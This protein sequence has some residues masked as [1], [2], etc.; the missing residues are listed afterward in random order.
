MQRE[1]QA[2][3]EEEK[4]ILQEDL[5][6]KDAAIMAARREYWTQIREEMLA[7][8]K[9]LPTGRKQK[10]KKE[11][12]QNIPKREGWLFSKEFFSLLFI[13]NNQMNFNDDL[14]TLLAE[15]NDSS[16]IKKFDDSKKYNAQ[17]QLKNSWF[18][19]IWEFQV[20]WKTKEGAKIVHS[21][22]GSE[23]P[24][25]SEIMGDWFSRTI[26]YGIRP[27]DW[28]ERAKNYMVALDYYMANRIFNVIGIWNSEE[29]ENLDVWFLLVACRFIMENNLVLAKSRVVRGLEI[30]PDHPLLQKLGKLVESGVKA[31]NFDPWVFLQG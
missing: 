12:V 10:V 28:L 19:G 15:W 20:F 23:I 29:L 5:R 14:A 6:T 4:K 18:D 9:D 22:K 11:I 3:A 21:V 1:A 26:T 13:I 31:E 2:R 27:D 16:K 25:A 17:L 7:K 30:N 24:G 8:L